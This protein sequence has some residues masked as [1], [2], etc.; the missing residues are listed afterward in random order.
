MKSSMVWDKIPWT[1]E[2]E[3]VKGIESKEVVGFAFSD[4]EKELG[5]SDADDKRKKKGDVG[6]TFVVMD[7]RE[8]GFSMIANRGF[9]SLA[10]VLVDCDFSLC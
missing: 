5:E 10:V 7:A 4:K 2:E 6:S 3:I 8:H 1:S 9:H